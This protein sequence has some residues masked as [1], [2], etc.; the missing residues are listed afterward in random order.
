MQTGGLL[1]GAL[2]KISIACC[3]LLRG[4]GDG[5]GGAT[6]ITDDAGEARGHTFDRMQ[7]ASA[8]IFIGFDHYGKVAFGDFAGNFDRKSRFSAQLFNQGAS[9]Q[10]TQR[11]GK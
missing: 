7:Q 2:R 8:V 6:Y 3:N 9:D 5:I 11:Y 10:D 1:L 4:G